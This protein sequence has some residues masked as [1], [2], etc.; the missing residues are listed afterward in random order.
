MGTLTIGSAPARI[1]AR[2]LCAA[3]PAILASAHAQAGEITGLAWHSGV[4]SVAGEFIV[5]PSDP[6]N[7]DVAGV[8]PNVVFILQKNYVGIG[9]V[10]IEFTVADTGGVTEYRI[11]EG[12]N[13][14]TGL[15][16]SGYHLELGFGVGSGFVKAAAGGGLDFDAPDFNSPNTFGP[17]FTGLPPTELDLIAT[18]FMPHAAFASGILFHIDVPD[19][20]TTFTLRQSPIAVPEP[21]SIAGLLIVL[22]LGR[23]ARR[24]WRIAR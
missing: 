12:V 23:R 5:A 18:G 9:P 14:S 20:I 15:D 13:N 10:D 2:V 24:E 8:S 7:D 16:W 6:N 22:V 3:L 1:L 17:F 19:G 21:T 4:A 11:E